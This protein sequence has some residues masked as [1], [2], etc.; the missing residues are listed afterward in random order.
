MKVCNLYPQYQVLPDRRSQS[1]SISD[2]RR[3][4]SERRSSERLKLD[5]NLTKDI[6]VVRNSVSALKKDTANFEGTN[7]IP[8]VSKFL[9]AIESFKNQEIGKTNLLDTKLKQ[10]NK[11]QSTKST[12]YES[13][14][15]L[16]GALASA[17]SLLFLGAAGVIVSLGAGIYLGCKAVKNVITSHIKN[18]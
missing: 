16:G 18:L 14:G 9:S 7:N 4:G 5:T 6:F 1:C 12:T 10:D 11:V 13:A 17:M 2:D 3:S 15:L 8:F